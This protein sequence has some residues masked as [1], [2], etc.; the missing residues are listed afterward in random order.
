[1]AD[2]A[3][4][5]ALTRAVLPGYVASTVGY[6]PLPRAAPADRGDEQRIHRGLPSPYLTVIVSLAGPVVTGTT[7]AD[8]LEGDPVRLGVLVGGLAQRPS[9]V[10]PDPQQCGVQL[11]VHPLAARA[12]FGLPAAALPEVGDGI[13]LLGRGV[14]E[15]RE[16]LVATRTWPARFALVEE[17]LR[18]RLDVRSPGRVRPEVVEAWR[19]M[20]WCRGAGTMSGLARHV[21]LSPRQLST[22]FAREVGM[23]PKQVSRLMRFDHAK[24]RIARIV[25]EG[26]GLDLTDVALT[27][28]YYD[29]AHLDRDFSQYTGTS[30]TGWLAEERRNIQARGHRNGEDWSHG[31]HTTPDRLG[32]AAGP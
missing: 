11:A 20:A 31:H 25:A 3:S 26:R 18:Q 6:G 7:E 13:D 24:Q 23:S 21:S 15:L 30:P 5:F 22:L 32:H 9:Y 4:G 29:H 19:W 14:S 17:Q 2:V 16:R 28:G 12:L 8:A 10:V 1:M 27:C